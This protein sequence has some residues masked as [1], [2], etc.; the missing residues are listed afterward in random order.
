M[1]WHTIAEGLKYFN[2]MLHLVA[3]V[4]NQLTE[5]NLKNMVRECHAPLSVEYK[6]VDETSFL[7]LLCQTPVLQGPR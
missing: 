5:S 2:Q 6:D 3:G 4:G 7:E 1:K